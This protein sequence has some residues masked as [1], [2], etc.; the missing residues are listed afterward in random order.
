RGTGV[1][2]WTLQDELRAFNR[3]YF[4]GGVLNTGNQNITMMSTQGEIYIARSTFIGAPIVANLGSSTITASLVQSDYAIFGVTINAGTSTIAVQNFTSGDHN[5]YNVVFNGG[6]SVGFISST[7]NAGSYN[8]ID[9]NSGTEFTLEGGPTINGRLRLGVPGLNTSIEAGS[10]TIFNGILESF[11]TLAQRINIF[12]SS[13]G[14]PAVFQKSN[15]NFCVAFITLRDNT[16]AGSADFYASNSIDLGNNVNWNFTSQSC[17]VILPVHLLSFDVA[18]T[19]G[20]ILFNWKTAT[21]I[22]S[23]HFEIQKQVNTGWITI[24]NVTAGGESQSER[25]YRF[26]SGEQGGVYRLVTVDRD[27]KKSYSAI[28]TIQCGSIEN[29]M[30][31]P[32]PVQRELQLQIKSTKNERMHLQIINSLGQVIRNEEVVVI[33][34]INQFKFNLYA[35]PTGKYVLSIQSKAIKIPFLKMR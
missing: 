27:G 10:T 2:S 30:I 7:N 35:L 13:T 21:E 32:N 33:P 16:K 4:Q 15:G 23:S 29:I 8:N 34:G 11:G 28:K 31:A 5:Y 19:S 1:G 9:V 26:Q 18:C 17:L 12:S 22:N 3:I 6:G 20:N 14:S 24:S 25:T